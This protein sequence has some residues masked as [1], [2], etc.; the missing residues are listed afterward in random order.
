MVPNS[1]RTPC[2]VPWRSS[3]RSLQRSEEVRPFQRVPRGR[4][5]RNGHRRRC[6]RRYG[7]YRFKGRCTNDRWGAWQRPRNKSTCSKVPAAKVHEL[8]IQF[9]GLD[10]SL[11]LRHRSKLE[12]SVIRYNTVQRTFLKVQQHSNLNITHGV[13]NTVQTFQLKYLSLF[14]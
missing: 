4:L 1:V 13:T 8:N 14:P 6:R 12:L 3:M 7:C 2:T 9:A 11:S 5:R 10:Q